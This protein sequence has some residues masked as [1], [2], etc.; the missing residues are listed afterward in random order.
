M[1]RLS[2]G[3][4]MEAEI[5]RRVP[6]EG[7]IHGNGG[8]WSVNKGGCQVDVVEHLVGANLWLLLPGGGGGGPFIPLT[9]GPKATRRN[10]SRSHPLV[11]HM[12][13]YSQRARS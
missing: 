3:Q 13:S 5:D 9:A 2:A 12:G 8:G 7:A 11:S 1:G 10:V 6:G 4:P